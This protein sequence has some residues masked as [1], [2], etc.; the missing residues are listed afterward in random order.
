MILKKTAEAVFFY[1]G[2]N[3]LKRYTILYH[4]RLLAS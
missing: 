1:V 3:Q 2:N 4:A